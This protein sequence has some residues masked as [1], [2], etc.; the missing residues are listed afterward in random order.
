MSLI[1]RLVRVTLD[2]ADGSV[3]AGATRPGQVVAN[4]AAA[5]WTFSAGELGNIT[6]LARP[7]A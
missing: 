4:I 1:T 3:I 7:A 5:D 2:N 6:T